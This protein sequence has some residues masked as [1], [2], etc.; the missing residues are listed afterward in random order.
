MFIAC[1]AR[2]QAL[3]RPFVSLFDGPW[4]TH[5]CRRRNG[6]R[7]PAHRPV[8]E[9]RAQTRQTQRPGPARAKG[10]GQD[11]H[12][13]GTPGR[14]HDGGEE[15][16]VRTYQNT[17]GL[18]VTGRIDRQLV[19]GLENSL[20]V[21]VLLK[22][23]D[24]VRIENMGAAREALLSHPATRDLVPGKKMRSPTPPAIKSRAWK[25]L[26]FAAS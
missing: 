2:A 15:A 16:A 9:G 3:L 5:D 19:E 8:A 7:R 6:D 24:Q 20:Q 11:R 23:L 13:Q 10:A 14:P 21:R 1:Q 26:P 18:R 25:T 4:R 17:T 22:R 12:L